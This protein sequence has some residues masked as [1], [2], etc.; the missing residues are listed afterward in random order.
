MNREIMYSYQSVVNK[1]NDSKPNIVRGSSPKLLSPQGA[2]YR[3]ELLSQIQEKERALAFDQRNKIENSSKEKLLITEFPIISGKGFRYLTREEDGSGETYSGD[4]RYNK[5][6]GFGTK[7]YPDGSYYTGEWVD[8]I[9]KGKGKAEF[10][11]KGTGIGVSERE[12]LI[13]GIWENG[14]PIYGVYYFPNN[15]PYRV[16][17]GNIHNWQPNGMGTLEYKNKI[18]YCGD[19]K[20]GKEE[21]F[22]KMSFPDGATYEGN[23]HAGVFNGWGKFISNEFTYDGYWFLGKT[24]GFGAATYKENIWYTGY[25]D[26]GNFNGKGIYSN[27]ITIEGKWNNGKVVVSPIFDNYNNSFV[28]SDLK[29]SKKIICDPIYNRSRSKV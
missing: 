14:F 6:H 4:W 11:L 17:S 15:S 7:T 12:Y 26:M 22:G 29:S 23:F 2:R 9:E 16:Y 20:N 28:S 10:M 24:H 19:I 5:P 13:E 25:F 1:Y 18:V 21:G 8:G 3:D 27:A